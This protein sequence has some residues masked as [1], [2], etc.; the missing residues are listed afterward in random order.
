MSW[1]FDGPLLQ[2]FPGHMAIVD[3]VDIDPTGEFIASVS[4]DFTAKVYHLTDAKLLHSISLGRHSPKGVCFLDPQTV[5]VTNY[6]GALIKI[7]L[8]NGNVLTRTIAENGISA[9]ARSGKHLVAVSYDGVA[10]LVRTTDL[11]VVNM[12]RSMQ[13]RLEPSALIRPS[14]GLSPATT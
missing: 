4:R 9:V 1:S 14:A 5:I 8:A 11:Q 2:S 6:W 3:D 10:Y 12:Y 7:D 13:Q